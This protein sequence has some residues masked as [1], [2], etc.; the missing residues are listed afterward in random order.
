MGMSLNHTIVGARDKEKPASVLLV[1]TA[2][3]D[4]PPPSGQAHE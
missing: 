3:R 2:R 1:R 4:R